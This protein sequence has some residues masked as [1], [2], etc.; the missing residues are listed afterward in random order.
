MI[1][2]APL[3]AL[4]IAFP[5]ASL[6]LAEEAT[7][8]PTLA[9]APSPLQGDLLARLEALGFENL[10]V[11]DTGNGLTIWYENRR[12]FLEIE[13]MGKLLREAS[14]GLGDDTWLEVV[15]QR[16]RIPL[17][18]V[19]TRVGTYRDFVDGR[20]GDEAFANSLS[21]GPAPESPPLRSSNSS[22]FRTDLDL[23]PGYFFAVDFRGWLNATLRT[24]VGDGLAVTTRGRYYLSP[25]GETGWTFAQAQG[26]RWLLPGVLGS[27]VAGRWDAS[28]YGA[29]GEIASQLDGGNWIW[30]LNGGLGTGMPLLASTSVERRFHPLDIGLSG[31]V[32]V[33]QEGDR[34][35]FARLTRWYSRSSLEASAWRSDLGTQFR[36]GLTLFLGPNPKPMPASFRV[37]APGLFSADYR[38]TIPKA[39][40]MPFP[41][42]DADSIWNRLSPSYVRAHVQAWR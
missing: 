16:D 39:G 34:A 2:L 42:T 12:W 7:P 1:Y 21:M 31:G 3:C 40:T 15:P 23:T 24:P 29:H 17:M 9:Q 41:V 10:A 6:T 4:L 20:L 19:R 8:S 25:W 14:V 38:A 27:W 30:R 18:T 35:L 13:A 33:F 11:V 26:H 37:F 5:L 22:L 32:G 36:L 28:N